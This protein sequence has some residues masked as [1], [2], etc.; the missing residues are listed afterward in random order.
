MTQPQQPFGE[1]PLTAMLRSHALADADL[2]ARARRRAADACAPPLAE[3]C[4][5]LDT[6]GVLRRQAEQIAAL[7]TTVA[8]LR[9]RLDDHLNRQAL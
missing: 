6:A 3:L 9:A 8:E 2:L 7:E 4:E 5:T 1:G